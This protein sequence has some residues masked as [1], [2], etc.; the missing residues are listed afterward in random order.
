MRTEMGM[1]NDT[2][3]K[4]GM[5]LKNEDEAEKYNPRIVTISTCEDIMMSDH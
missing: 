1:K 3:M 5:R 4:M 2:P